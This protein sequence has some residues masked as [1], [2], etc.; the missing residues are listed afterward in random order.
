MGLFDIYR[1]MNE[2]APMGRAAIITVDVK[3]EKRADFAKWFG[4]HGH[5]EGGD[6][7]R[8]W[9]CGER[10]AA[11]PVGVVVQKG[12]AVQHVITMNVPVPSCAQCRETLVARAR[13]ATRCHHAGF[14]A[15]IA[16]VIALLAMEGQTPT[17]W[18]KAII[19]GVLL[20]VFIAGVIG[21]CLGWIAVR[22]SARKTSALRSELDHPLV[23]RVRQD[24]WRPMGAR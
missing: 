19:F 16:G 6:D 10:D 23:K 15:G 14:L 20:T 11:E 5:A 8:C 24:G 9:Y 17:D 7:K 18:I 4:E 3:E 22:A 13:A 21:S 12:L 1:Y 2:R